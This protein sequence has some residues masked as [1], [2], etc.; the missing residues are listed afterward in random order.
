MF[1]KYPVPVV[2]LFSLVLQSTPTRA[3]DIPYESLQAHEGGVGPVRLKMNVDKASAKLGVDIEKAPYQYGDE[4]CS[5]CAFGES[6][7]D[8]NMRF[9]VSD[10]K[11]GK[12]DVYI[13]KVRT[14]DDL[15]VGSTSEDIFAVY[16]DR[17]RLRPAHEP[18]ESVLS[19]KTGNKRYIS[20]TGPHPGEVK[21]G[22]N[23]TNHPPSEVSSYSIGVFGVG[24]VEGCL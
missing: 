2:V 24:S 1:A 23:E 14:E 21:R 3:K 5:S 16:G 4:E 11:I 12:I 10:G 22:M 8:W 6:E 7:Y 19:V 18:S 17:A 13:D 20:F 15:G 9:I